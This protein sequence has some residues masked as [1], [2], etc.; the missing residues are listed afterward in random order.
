MA[1]LGSRLGLLAGTDRT[2][3]VWTDTRGGTVESNKQVWRWPR[4]LF[5]IRRG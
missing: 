2:S 1:D 3:A 5:P 4:W